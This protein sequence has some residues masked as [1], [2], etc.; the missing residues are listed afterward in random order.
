MKSASAFIASL[1]GVVCI[2]AA[3]LYFVRIYDRT[4]EA[5]ALKV[6]AVA[7][8]WWWEFDYPSLGVRTSDVL[9]LPSGRD[10][11]LELRSG[12]VIHSFWI[13]GM[14]DSV[15]IIPGKTRLLDLVVKSPGE[16]YGNCDSGCGCGT[17][18]MRFRVMASAPLQFQRWAADARLR[19]SEFKPPQMADTP[20]CALRTS[21]GGHAARNSPVSRLQ[22]LLDDKSSTAGRLLH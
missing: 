7:H 1:V 10:V 4:A 3:V 18:C 19:R 16:L 13:A 14:K 2:S 9:Y 21:H 17:V 22:Q 11:R 6:R 12:D 5:P 20:D 15:D 8:Q